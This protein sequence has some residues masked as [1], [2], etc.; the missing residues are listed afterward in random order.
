MDCI[1]I[2]LTLQTVDGIIHTSD[3][4]ALVLFRMRGLTHHGHRLGTMV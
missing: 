4:C 1:I 2:R 3:H